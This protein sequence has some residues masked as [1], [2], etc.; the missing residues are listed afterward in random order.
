[1]TMVMIEQ[2]KERWR[3]DRQGLSDKSKLQG[4]GDMVVVSWGNGDATGRHHA[5]GLE[6]PL[7]SVVHRQGTK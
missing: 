3:Q 4:P 6:L 2:R 5:C 1:M 7:G